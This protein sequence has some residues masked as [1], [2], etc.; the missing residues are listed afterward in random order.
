MHRPP[1]RNH[2]HNLIALSWHIGPLIGNLRSQTHIADKLN[3]HAAAVLDVAWN[4]SHIAPEA[5]HTKN[6]VQVTAQ[7]GAWLEHFR[8]VQIE[9]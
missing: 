7:K 1:A 3:Q 5:E 8:D 9:F 4:E 2:L 6:R